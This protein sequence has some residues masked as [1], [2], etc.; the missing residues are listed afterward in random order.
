MNNKLKW[1]IGIL[2]AVGLATLF[3]WAYLYEKQQEQLYYNICREHGGSDADCKLF[4]TYAGNI[5]IHLANGE[6]ISRS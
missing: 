4:A 5:K 3:R 2:V 6:T 1:A